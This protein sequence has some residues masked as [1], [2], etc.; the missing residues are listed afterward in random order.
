MTTGLDKAIR[1]LGI[2]AAILCF[3]M[4]N[5]RF[6]WQAG[7]GAPAWVNNGHWTTPFSGMPFS[8]LEPSLHPYAVSFPLDFLLKNNALAAILALFIILLTRIR[9]VVNFLFFMIVGLCFGIIAYAALSF[10]PWYMSDLGRKVQPFCFSILCLFTLCCFE[11]AL[12]QLI[13]FF[14][15]EHVRRAGAITSIL[16]AVIGVSAVGCYV[17]HYLSDARI[18]M[19]DAASK[20]DIGKV[21]KLLARNPALAEA[22]DV[23]GITP[24]HIAALRGDKTLAEVLIRNGANVNSTRPGSG[25]TP[26]HWA[27]RNSTTN[28]AETLRANGA[29]INACIGSTGTPLHQAAR[30]GTRDVAEWLISHGA[31]VDSRNDEGLTPLHRA[32]KAG[33]LDVIKLL[34]EKGADVHATAGAGTTPLHW[35]TT[36]RA[37]KLL[38]DAGAEVNARDNSGDT[39]LYMTLTIQ[40]VP[41][42]DFLIDNGADINAIGDPRGTPLA[43]AA[44]YC[45][46]PIVAHL[47]A[48]GAD[49]NAHSANTCSPFRAALDARRFD[50]ARLLI[51]HGATNA[52]VEELRIIG[53][54]AF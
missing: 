50:I 3:V 14:R 28:L 6:E 39:P 16:L 52:V 32:A 46:K 45:S 35:A 8:M 12:L 38:L 23:S 24:L 27:C 15:N 41:L 37:A 54:A 7:L 1:T 9:I 30:W 20:G 18:M 22:K 47:V 48:R 2:L 34:I 17:G 26:L 43:V 13:N 49:V 31:V 51:E 29:D 25:I 42:M 11:I 40:K 36:P 33:S 5:S 53:P 10:F 21:E 19:L 4:A 44:R